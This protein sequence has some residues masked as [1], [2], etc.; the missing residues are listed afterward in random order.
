M[1]IRSRGTPSAESWRTHWMESSWRRAETLSRC[2]GAAVLEQRG[3]G[4]RT[5]ICCSALRQW[6]V[7]Y[8]RVR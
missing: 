6:P 7:G 5:Y 3:V 8:G 2:A 4:G 1:L